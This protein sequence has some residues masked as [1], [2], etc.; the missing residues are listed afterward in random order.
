MLEALYNDTLD[1]LDLTNSEVGDAVILQICEFLRCS[2]VRAVKFIRCKLTDDVVN[3]II[4]AMGNIITLNLSQNYLTDA[5]LG[6][7]ASRREAMPALKTV[8]L[9]QNK[10]IERKHRASIERLRQTDLIV[11]V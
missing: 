3:K 6:R 5:V 4:P 9:C 2:K 8:I 11:S 1:T 7:L 10:I